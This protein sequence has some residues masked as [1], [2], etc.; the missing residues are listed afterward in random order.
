M[1]S[2]SWPWPAGLGHW[3][4]ECKTAGLGAGGGRAARAEA[5]VERRG[6]RQRQSGA[7]KG[8]GG[9][10]PGRGGGGATSVH[11]GG[12]GGAA[13]ARTEAE[14]SR[15]RRRRGASV[16]G[17]VGLELGF[18]VFIR[19]LDV[20]PVDYWAQ[21]ALMGCSLVVR[22]TEEPNRR[23]WEFRFQRIRNRT[24]TDFLGSGSFDSGSRFFRFD[25]RF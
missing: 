11:G 20:G 3:P 9:V 18:F 13:P 17:G 22:L 15:R 24:R 16:A 12:G 1:A 7:G 6:R 2:S 4:R 14:R 10:A 25:Y 19:L 5:Q 21:N 8:G 23:T